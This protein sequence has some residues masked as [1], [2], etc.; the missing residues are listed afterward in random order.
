MWYCPDFLTI[1]A[2][3]NPHQSGWASTAPKSALTK[4]VMINILLNSMTTFSLH[5][6]FISIQQKAYHSLPF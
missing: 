5:L 6:I 3:L 4:T 1:H 2:L